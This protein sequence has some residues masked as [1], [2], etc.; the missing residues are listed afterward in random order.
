M[1]LNDVWLNV[2]KEI[3]FYTKETFEKIP[4]GP[5]VYAWFYPLRIITKDPYQFIREVN[6]I[7]NYD[8]YINGKPSKNGLVEFK[9]ETIDF[10]LEVNF[11]EP[12]LDSFLEIWQNAT[13]SES[14]FDQ[15]RRV[16]MKA[17]IFMPPLYVG[18]TIQLRRR[19]LEHI[20]C[21]DGKNSFNSRYN[22]FARKNTMKFDRVEDLLFV[23]IR[24]IEETN[25]ESQDDIE[26]L[27]GLVEAIMKNLSKPI[28]SEK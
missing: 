21:N 18:K 6:L 5:G 7:L 24:T 2:N 1:R 27:E 25:G 11:K 9:W 22:N 26:D 23:C 12:N 20:T 10:N 17:S 4:D 13:E 8:S 15:L 16:I 28:Y 19:S 14:S 3:G